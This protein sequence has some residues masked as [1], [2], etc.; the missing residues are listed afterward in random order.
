MDI[1]SRD[2]SSATLI[3]VKGRIDAMT[4]PEF[5][6]YLSNLLQQ[7]KKNNLIINLGELE[8]ISSA[9][10]R[11]ILSVA[12]KVKANQGNLLFCGLQGSAKEIFEM[13]GFCS[14]LQVL[15][16]EEEALTKI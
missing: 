9:G 10:L 6:D 11:V 12:K 15:D 3:S 8:Y 1:V 7:E 2:D 14:I 5:E 13:S 4:S 16:T